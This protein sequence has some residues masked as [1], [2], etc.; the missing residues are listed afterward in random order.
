VSAFRVGCARPSR[1]LTEG[2]DATGQ[3]G[4]GEEIAAANPMSHRYTLRVTR[5]DGRTHGS[6]ANGRWRATDD[7][8]TNETHMH[9][10]V[11]ESDQNRSD[12][13]TGLI[14]LH[15]A[16]AKAMRA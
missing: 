3:T 8:I 14:T 6:C 7:L 12:S 13:V 16:M 11:K 5:A 2:D 10:L 15:N 1:H 4:A 9:G